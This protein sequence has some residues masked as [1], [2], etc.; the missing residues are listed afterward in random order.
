[1]WPPCCA[2]GGRRASAAAWTRRVV[3]R[4]IRTG[5]PV[6]AMAWALLV[7]AEP[8]SATPSPARRASAPMESSRS[9][10]QG[11][12]HARMSA[13]IL[14]RLGLA[15]PLARAGTRRAGAPPGTQPQAHIGPRRTEGLPRAGGD[16]GGVPAADWRGVAVSPQ[17]TARASQ[18]ARGRAGAPWHTVGRAWE[19]E[20]PAWGWPP[21][22]ARARVVTSG[23]ATGR[24]T[25][26]PRGGPA[27]WARPAHSAARWGTSAHAAD[28]RR[29]DGC[30]PSAR[31]Q[32]A[33]HLSPGR[34]R[35]EGWR[36]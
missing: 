34:V 36:R 14:E 33:W 15:V 24:N 25:G 19:Q 7:V 18:A 22:P 20:G 29:C 12:S 28:G 35:S 10:A 32:R 5:P 16:R 21:W 2:V 26:R 4:A 9:R 23:R 13:G 8:L 6:A 1:M 30:S 27:A 17:G 11:G 31:C 3:R